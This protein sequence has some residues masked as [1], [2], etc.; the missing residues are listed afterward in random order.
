MCS[1]LDRRV[2]FLIITL[3]LLGAIAMTHL[4]LPDA[5]A[6]VAAGEERV[7]DRDGRVVSYYVHGE[8]PTVVL[9]ASAGREVSD[10]N[11]LIDKLA[12]GGHRTIAVEAP[13]IGQS[14][15]PD[16]DMDLWDLA[17]DV[18]ALMTAE[19]DRRK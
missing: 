8:G 18:H 10:F 1:L 4:P 3:I 19:G 5:K 11:E 7:I 15:L 6:R 17:V 14:E 16:D 13:G 2:I 12:G 9:L